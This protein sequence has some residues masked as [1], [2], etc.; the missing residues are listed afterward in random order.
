[1]RTISL[2]ALA[3]A[4]GTAAPAFAQDADPVFFDGPYIG[5][6]LSLDVPEDGGGDGIVFDTNGDGIYDNTVRTV[7]GSEVR[8]RA[9]TCL[10]QRAMPG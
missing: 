3:V 1:M 6:T 8:P 7:T 9:P 2:V 10:C 4:M 5:G